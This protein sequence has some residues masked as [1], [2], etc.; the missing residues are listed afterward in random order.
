[1]RYT[2]PG[3]IRYLLGPGQGWGDGG[4]VRTLGSALQSCWKQ[5]RQL[6]FLLLDDVLWWNL[7]EML[8]LCIVNGGVNPYI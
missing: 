7:E 1:M 3:S 4:E 5:D 2:F 8:G 6:F